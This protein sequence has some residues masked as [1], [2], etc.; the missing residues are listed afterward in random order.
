MKNQQPILIK[1]TFVH[2]LQEIVLSEISK[3]PELKDLIRIVERGVDYL[4]FDFIPA[5]IENS[6]ENPS[7]DSPTD[8]S[9]SSNSSKK[10]KTKDEENEDS[11]TI[12]DSFLK[13][14][15]KLIQL[16]SITNIYLV[17]KGEKLHPIHINNHKSILGT[18]IEL[19][20]H[21][22]LTSKSKSIT[23]SIKAYKTFKLRCAGSDSP[24][25]ILIQK[26]ISDTFKL[27]L[28][29]DADLDTYIHKPGEL[30]EVGVRVTP[31]PISVRNYKVENIKGGMNSA[32]A[33]AVN[34]FALK[35]LDT[36]SPFSYLNICSGSA[37]LL[38]EAGTDIQAQFGNSIL[39]PTNI[40]TTIK[41]LGFDIDNKTNSLAIQ[42]IKKAGFIRSIQIK[43]ADLLDKPDFG[44]FNTITSD[45]P[46]GMQIAKGTDLNK[47]YK[48]FVEYV[49]S[50]LNQTG[51]LVVYTTE[52][53][54]FENA[55]RG[56]KLHIEK[57]LNLQITTIVN[58]HI[59]PKIFVCTFK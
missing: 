26:Y 15:E 42:N 35:K 4:Y 56:S 9:E 27:T 13:T 37:T 3:Y 19:V 32:V 58:S 55:L 25:A 52:I 47:L 10:L 30:W 12:V 40:P 6:L 5:I 21:L 51:T 8:T 31:R 45:L 20:L 46:F 59:H 38:L 44:M 2:G 49:E 43:T 11:A 54:T 14:L 39:T 17:Q 18:M 33:Y 29:E 48:A 23:K 34:T 36:V 1:L 57:T 7:E 24:E 28:S 53:D 50:H 22:H 16:R 41:L